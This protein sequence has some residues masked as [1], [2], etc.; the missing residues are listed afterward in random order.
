MIDEQDAER[1]ENLDRRKVLL[2]LAFASAT[3][4]AAMRLPAEPVNYLGKRKL[5]NIVPKRIGNWEF[6]T[7]SGL[8]VPPE[9]QLSKMTYS[10]LLTRVYS[11]GVNP[12]I[13]F[14]VAQSA[15]QTGILQVHR[16]EACYP[17]GGYRLSSIEPRTVSLPSGDFVANELTA[18]AADRTE[19]IIYWTRIG[20]H[21]P[22]SW[23]QQR[24]VVA[25]DNLKGLIP[26]AVLVRVSM[27]TQD[28]AMALELM[29]GFIRQL[30]TNL[31]PVSQKV[32]VPVA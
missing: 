15:G 14:L 32:F 27:V 11:D 23:S 25:M 13:M 18:T 10:Q 20:D 5:E 16:P 22:P 30:V 21:L 1:P 19:Q 17:A 12:P 26:D 24:L 2:G 31:P 9:D 29:E 4:L 8:V 3:G 7:A 6:V 28:K